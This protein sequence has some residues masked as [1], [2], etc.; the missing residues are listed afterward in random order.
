MNAR[1]DITSALGQRVEGAIASVPGLAGG[2]WRIAALPVASPIHR[3]T[4]SDCVIVDVPGNDPV[5]IKFRQPDVATTA[6]PSATTAARRAAATGVAPTVIA[7]GSDWLALAFLA[8][9]W[10]YARVGD[11]QD[12]ELTTKVLEAKKALHETG[13]IGEGFSPFAMIETLASEATALGVPLPDETDR[14][15]ALARLVRAAISASGIDPC[16]CHNDGIASNVMIDGNGVQLVDFDLAADNDPWFDV[17]A[18]I[19]EVCNFDAER[20]AMVEHYAGHLDERLYNRCRLYGAIDDLMWGLWG[21]TTAIRTSR[22]GIEFWKYGA[23]RLFHARTTFNAR[24][25]ELWLRRL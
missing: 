22:T 25:F 11:L 1:T 3:A 23:W 12:L 10:R 4:A 19:N 8:P 15:I 20:H 21:V 9:P 6:L 7:D 5:F 16:F 13:L 2:T 24:D 18:L 14:L 17:G